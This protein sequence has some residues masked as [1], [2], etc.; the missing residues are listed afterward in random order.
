MRY[1]DRLHPLALL[2]LRVVLGV[3]MVAH[4]STKVFGGL[5]AH[6]HF[7]SGLG[8]PGWLAYLSAAAEFVG[9]IL[10]LVGLFTR[11]AAL[12]IFADMFV[13]IWKVHF[14]HGLL[15]DGGY[16]FP[17]ALAAISFAL[18]FLGGGP[19]ALDS[20]R[21]GGGKSSKG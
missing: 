10:V 9:G 5:Q 19:I 14:K 4:G 21:S 15:G 13:A 8:V 2:T 18:V 11:I 16:Q 6:V 3:I 1:L 20:V 12:A 17:L 7:V